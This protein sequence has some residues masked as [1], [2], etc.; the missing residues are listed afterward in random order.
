MILSV[1]ESVGIGSTEIESV[2]VRGERGTPNR[3]E[4]FRVAVFCVQRVDVCG[5][6]FLEPVAKPVPPAM[7]FREFFV[8]ETQVLSSPEVGVEVVSS[9]Q[10]E[11]RVGFPPAETLRDDGLE[12]A[13]PAVG[14]TDK[15]QNLPGRCCS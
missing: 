6:Q 1:N 5:C 11:R 12:Q 13:F 15:S 2:V 7:I 9:Y 14:R 3:P 8:A 10:P 4:G